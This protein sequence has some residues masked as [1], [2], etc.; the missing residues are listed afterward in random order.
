MM[1]IG[2]VREWER[3]EIKKRQKMLENKEAREEFERPII[4]RDKKIGERR[5]KFLQQISE[6]F[7]TQKI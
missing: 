4:Y 6:K 5:L 3:N 2:S 7:S 1:K